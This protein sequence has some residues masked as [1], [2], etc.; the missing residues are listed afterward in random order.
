MQRAKIRKTTTAFAWALLLGWTS[1]THAV[2]LNL[3]C[4]AS[5][6]QYK[7]CTK[8]AQIWAQRTGNKVNVTADTTNSSNASLERYQLQMETGVLAADVLAIDVVWLGT[9]GSNL[10]DLNPYL[11]DADKAGFFVNMLNSDVKN[12]KQLALPWYSEVGLLYYRKDLLKKYGFDA[13]PPSWIEFFGMASVIQ[14]GERAK[15]SAFAGYASPRVSDENFTCVALEWISSYASGTIINNKGDVIILN[16][17]SLEAVK[18]FSNRLKDI[19]PP[20][21]SNF[22]AAE[23]RKVWLAGN[24]AFMRDWPLAYGLSQGKDSRVKDKFG[25]AILPK[26]GL[27]GKS[28][29]ALGGWQLAANKQTK[30]PKEAADL[31]RFLTSVEVQKERIN[32]GALPTQKSLFQNKEVLKS[33]PYMADMFEAY[34]N[35]VARP[36]SI[37]GKKYPKVSEIFRGAINDIL[38]GTIP[39]REGLQ[40]LEDDLN[41]LKG[42]GW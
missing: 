34:N 7:A 41:K 38:A 8:Y 39:A 10:L 16:N 35:T 18:L 19:Y 25:V 29:S 28:V 27:Y 42:T 5:D 12:D 2:T 22:G 15:N 4:Q 21:S 30:S 11:K 14:A 24:A 17:G 23:M 20:N 36:S 40:K 31:I 32:E 33:K 6:D 1:H 9:L 3:E 37:T 13:P 26:G